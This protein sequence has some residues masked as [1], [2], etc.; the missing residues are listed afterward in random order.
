[1]SVAAPDRCPLCG[2]E[3]GGGSVVVQ[4]RTYHDTTLRGQRYL[5][6][7]LEVPGVCGGCSRGLLLKRWA[8]GALAVGSAVAVGVFGALI[9]AKPLLF[10]AGLYGL[11]LFRTLEYTWADWLLYGSDF[12]SR[13]AAYRP[14]G[15]ELSYPGSLW[16]FFG[17]IAAIPVL[18]VAFAVLGSL[19]GFLARGPRPKPSPRPSASAP[20]DPV[21]SVFLQPWNFVYPYVAP[22]QRLLRGSTLVA[23][24]REAAVPPQYT[25]RARVMS[26]RLLE[27]FLAEKQATHLELAD[28]RPP[29]RISRQQARDLLAE[30]DAQEKSK[31]KALQRPDE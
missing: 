21:R 5:V 15:D 1:M 28:V 7:T 26:R 13:L 25:A 23:Y 27:G 3:R 6:R 10:G 8:A 20:H 30:L 31:W 4:T 24:T 19:L 11:Y 17:R 12:E 16:H 29:P 2:G 22:N 18:F 14:E 9:E